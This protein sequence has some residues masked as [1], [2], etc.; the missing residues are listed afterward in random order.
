MSGQL[1]T[2]MFYNNFLFQND[3][4]IKGFGLLGPS[5]ESGSQYVGMSFYWVNSVN[6]GF[7]VTYQPQTIQTA[8]D[9]LQMPYTFCGLGRANN[10]VESFTVG[11]NGKKQ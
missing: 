1:N 5:I 2:Q 3:F 10:Y 7:K 8:Y 9:A 6:D 4:Y 11:R